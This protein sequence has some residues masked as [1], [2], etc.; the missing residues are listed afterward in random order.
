M[1][2]RFDELIKLS[3]ALELNPNYPEAHNNLGAAL[4]QGDLTAAIAYNTALQLKLNYP[5]AHNNLGNALKEMGDLTAAIAS[6]NT[7]L[8]PSPLPRGS[9]QPGRCT[10]R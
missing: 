9:K 6:Y 2:G 1:Q 5:D 7:A 8:Q 3:Q 4:E 10:Q